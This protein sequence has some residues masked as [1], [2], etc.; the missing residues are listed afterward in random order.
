M[1]ETTTQ[2][3]FEAGDNGKEYEVKAIWDSIVYTRE[4]KGH[5][6]GLYYL[7]LWKGYPKE[8]NTWEP[9]SAMQH[10]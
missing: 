6:P 2:L 5:L 7:V 4:L 3:K 10:L 8:K 9:A 1:N